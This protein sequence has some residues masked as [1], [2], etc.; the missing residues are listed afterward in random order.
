MPIVV[1]LNTS[2]GGIPKRPR[3]SV[4][5]V[6]A[7]LVGDG[8]DHEKHNTPKQA[9]CLIDVEVLERVAAEGFDVGPGALGENMTVRDADLESCGLG[10][11][12]RFEHG[13]LL[14]ITKRRKPCYVLD[15]IDPTL[16]VA[17]IDRI[18]W[19]AKVLKPGTVRPG[20]AFAIDRTARPDG[21]S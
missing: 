9:V 8:H 5:V 14:E 2:A 19:Y 21:G 20:D 16:K 7:G 12:I 6:E 13:P 4:E 18:G 11:R 3:P 17:M 10:D 15:A 1:S